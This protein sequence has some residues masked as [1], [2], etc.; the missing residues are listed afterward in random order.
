MLFGLIII[1]Y[2]SFN[3]IFLN[4]IEEPLTLLSI[5]S[6]VTIF[7]PMLILP[8]FVYYR[9]DVRIKGEYKDFKIYEGIKHR[10]F[11]LFVAIG[12][13]FLIV[14]LGLESIVDPYAMLSAFI[15]YFIAFIASA[16]MFNFIYFNYFENDLLRDVIKRYKELKKEEKTRSKK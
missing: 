12:T 6:N 15:T 4:A 5:A 13:I 2:I 8:W 14:R 3:P 1:V 9:L 7:V 11:R 10:M 16:F